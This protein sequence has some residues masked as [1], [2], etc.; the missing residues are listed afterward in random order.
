MKINQATAAGVV[1][2]V[3]MGGFVNGVLF[4]TILCSRAIR[5]TVNPPLTMTGVHTNMRWDGFFHTFIWLVTLLGIFM[6]WNVARSHAA[7]ATRLPTTKT[8]V[9]AMTLGG[10][11]FNLIEGVIDRRL[12]TLHNVGELTASSLW[13]VAVLAIGGALMVMVGAA[14][15][16]RRVRRLLSDERR[17]A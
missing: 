10:G 4:H 17:L 1:L 3:G 6:L 13:N 14:L 12:L 2:G 9:G 5:S 16:R 7:R 11:L 8:F 15:M